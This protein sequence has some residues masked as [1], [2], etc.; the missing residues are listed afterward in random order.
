MGWWIKFKVSMP[1]NNKLH[2]LTDEEFRIY[3]FLLCRMGEIN[4]ENG[5]VTDILNDSLALLSLKLPLSQQ[6]GEGYLTK[7]KSAIRT[8]RKQKL[9]SGRIG[10]L[11]IH[12]W[13]EIQGQNSTERVKRFR[14]RYGNVTGNVT[15]KIRQDKIRKEEPTGFFEAVKN[16]IFEMAHASEEI[17]SEL[18]SIGDVDAMIGR[19]IKALSDPKRKIAGHQVDPEPF[20]AFHVFGCWDRWFRNG[21]NGEMTLK[22][23]E[24]II[25]RLPLIKQG[26]Y[27]DKKYSDGHD[28]RWWA[29]TFN[30]Q[31]SGGK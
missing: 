4:E 5:E 31:E 21:H 25:L 22:H 19:W 13:K 24:N 29:K 18:L 2:K 16:K 10:N 1:R 12:K 9:I 14:K 23:L 3:V 7:I 6:F 8:F 30:I 17:Q 15:D 20:V 28:W 11:K 26:M 27:R